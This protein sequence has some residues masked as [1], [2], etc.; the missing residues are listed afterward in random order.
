MLTGRLVVED[1]QIYL[2]VMSNEEEL[3]QL[4]SYT[5]MCHNVVVMICQ[6]L[7]CMHCSSQ[8][9]S[10]LTGCAPDFLALKVSQRL[11]T[12]C[13]CLRLLIVHDCS[14]QR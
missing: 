11:Q 13:I 12:I 5:G 9:V 10:W 7:P 1:Q 14:C 3:C 8:D 4:V 6:Q 2:G